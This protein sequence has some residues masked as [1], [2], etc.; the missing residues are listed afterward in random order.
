MVIEGSF[1]NTCAHGTGLQV[2]KSNDLYIVLRK[3]RTF[4]LQ[5]CAKLTY[6]S[7]IRITVTVIESGG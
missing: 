2:R 5:R 4:T 6:Q 3:Y 7:C 1:K